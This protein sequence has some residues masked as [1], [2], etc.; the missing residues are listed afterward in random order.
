MRWIDGLSVI[1]QTGLMVN[2]TYI[3]A[4]QVSREGD[5]GDSRFIQFWTLVADELYP[6]VPAALLAWYIALTAVVGFS[7]FGSL[8]LV[9]CWWYWR[10]DKKNR[11]NRWRKRRQK[12]AEKISR[13]G[14]RLVVVPA[15]A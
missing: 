12:L 8:F 2:A 4:A 9:L 1:S 14:S 3:Y 10:Q 7:V 5:P 15:P 11:N 6:F 13:I